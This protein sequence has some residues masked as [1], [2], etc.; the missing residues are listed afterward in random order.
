[1]RVFTAGLDSLTAQAMH[2]ALA[3]GQLALSLAYAFVADGHVAPERYGDV[4]GPPELAAELDRQLQAAGRDAAA[5]DSTVRRV[6]R[7]GAIR[8][9]VDLRVWPEA[10]R[11][12]DVEGRMPSGFAALDVYC[13]DF[14]D[15]RRPE[16]IEK[17]VEI[18]AESVGGRP[19]RQRVTFARA[20]PD[21]YST[22]LR[23]P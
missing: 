19:V 5:R 22:G 20:H 1:E 2:G 15:G 18:E 8:I 7:A 3:N 17:S 21:V 14:R 10:V 16:L 13:F 23:F 11:R 12:V 9:G 6:V 4:S